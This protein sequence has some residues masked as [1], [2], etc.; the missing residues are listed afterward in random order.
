MT[1]AALSSSPA[2]CFLCLIV[3]IALVLIVP[4][5]I[6]LVVIPDDGSSRNDSPCTVAPFDSLLPATIAVEDPVRPHRLF[7][8]FAV[9]LDRIRS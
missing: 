9:S 3:L 5:L 1:S 6:A 7:R 4:L 8:V 2:I